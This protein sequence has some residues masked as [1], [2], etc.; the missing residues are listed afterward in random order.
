MAAAML[1]LGRRHDHDELK[2]SQSD[3]SLEH[4]LLAG[5]NCD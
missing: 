3:E 2:S 4:A 5:A 1:W